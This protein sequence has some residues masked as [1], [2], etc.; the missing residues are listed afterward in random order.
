MTAADPPYHCRAY[1]VNT[2]LRDTFSKERNIRSA[3]FNPA[4]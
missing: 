3:M 1:T 4:S 2:P